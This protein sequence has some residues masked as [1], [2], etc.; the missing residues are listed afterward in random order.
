VTNSVKTKKG[1][2][3]PSF[4]WHCNKQLRRSPGRGMRLF[5]FAEVV[6]RDAA[7]HRVHGA[8]QRLA[9]EGG[10]GVKAL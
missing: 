3:G 2:G 8:C 7:I 4:C 5:Y 1:A 6:D 9:V 10:D